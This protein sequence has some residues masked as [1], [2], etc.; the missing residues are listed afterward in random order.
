VNSLQAA[1]QATLARA[2]VGI[3]GADAV[4]EDPRERRLYRGGVW[5]PVDPDGRFGQTPALVVKPGSAGEVAACLRLIADAGF[6]VLAVGGGTGVTGGQ[7]PT[8]ETVVLDLA[9]LDRVHSVDRASR[10]ARADAGVKLGALAAAAEAEGLLFA[11]DPWS[12]TLASVG[13]AISTNGVGYLA[14]GYGTMGQQTLGLQ[15]ALTTGELVD[16]PAAQTSA[17]GPDLGRLFVGSEGTLGVITA[18]TIRL[19][20]QPERRLFLAARFR[21]FEDGFEA[22]QAAAAVR[23][24]LAMVDYEE[25]DEGPTSTLYAAVDGVR[26]AA[27]AVEER[28]RDLVL[29]ARGEIRPTAEVE[30]FWRTRHESAERYARRLAEHRA[31]LLASDED[32]PM[33]RPRRGWRYIHLA[34]PAGEVLAFREGA[35]QR[36]AE[37][38]VK[39]HSAGIWGS[40]DLF[41]FVLEGSPAKT[42]RTADELMLE[43]ARAGGSFEYCHGV[44]L[45]LAHLMPVAMGPAMPVLR[46]IKAA[47]DPSGLLN[48]GKQGLVR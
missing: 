15:V 29:A 19:F 4:V 10:R 31:A 13:G 8:A 35:R 44:G 47:L 12:Q 25:D 16:L 26:G 33:E 23:L 6:P 41:S 40:P 39:L 45:R 34:L 46:R 37:R 21:R 9:R 32:P 36:A 1:E 27:E 42:D 5:G 17:A 18:A 48:P 11:H 38:R 24:P 43:A 14:A 22:L 28:L 7:L 20:P 30:R 3:V 2:L